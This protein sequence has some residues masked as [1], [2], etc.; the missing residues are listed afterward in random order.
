MFVTVKRVDQLE[1]TSNQFARAC[2][3]YTLLNHAS[4]QYKP[5]VTLVLIP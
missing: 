5:M 4:L 1:S 2:D 3:L